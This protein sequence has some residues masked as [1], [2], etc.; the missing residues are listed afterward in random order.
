MARH[1]TEG[2]ILWRDFAI[3]TV[4]L[5]ETRAIVKSLLEPFRSMASPLLLAD[6]LDIELLCVGF[7]K[8]E[9]SGKA[10]QVVLSV[11]PIVQLPAWPC[12]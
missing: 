1:Q 10:G 5:Q 6:S 2:Q 3:P 4:S 11:S 7:M 9:F 12:P 8:L